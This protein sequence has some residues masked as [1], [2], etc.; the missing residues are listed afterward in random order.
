MTVSP[1][2]LIATLIA[3]GQIATSVLATHE[4]LLRQMVTICINSDLVLE[5]LSDRLLAQQLWANSTCTKQTNKQKTQYDY[6][7]IILP[8][9]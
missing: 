9:E 4:A 7:S 2:A 8:H 5:K 1:K 6:L 3:K